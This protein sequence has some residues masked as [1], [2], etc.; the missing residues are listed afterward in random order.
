MKLPK[1]LQKLFFPLLALLVLTT[2]LAPILAPASGGLGDIFHPKGN[3]IVNRYSDVI[4]QRGPTIIVAA[5]DSLN[6]FDVPP[7]YRCDGEADDEEIQA[8]IAAVATAGGGPVF[9]LAGTYSISTQLTTW[10]YGYVTILGESWAT[11]FKMADDANLNGMIALWWDGSTLR[12]LQLD[13]NKVNQ[14]S[15]GRLVNIGSVYDDTLINVDNCLFV[16][17]KDEGVRLENQATSRYTV[18]D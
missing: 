6:Y 5:S 4:D 14:S 12:D 11:I 18:R 13:G 15:N 2:A 16:D 1:R 17:G 8:A 10:G 3:P 9:C 7:K